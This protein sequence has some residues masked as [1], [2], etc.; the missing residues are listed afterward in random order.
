MKKALVNS[1]PVPVPEEGG[2]WTEVQTIQDI[3]IL[4][5]FNNHVLKA[6]HCV[7]TDTGEHATLKAGV[8]HKSQIYDAYGMIYEY[9][10]SRE[11]IKEVRISGKGRELIRKSINCTDAWVKKKGNEYGLIQWMEQNYNKEK[12]EGA[13]QRRI[14]RVNAIMSKVPEAPEDLKEWI[15]RAANGGMDYCIRN[16]ETKQ[17]TCSRCGA[18]FEEKR[19]V[20]VDGSKKVRNNDM[21]LCPEC[22]TAVQLKRRVHSRDIRVHF[23]LVQPIDEECS[24]MRHFD[25][26]IICKGKKQ[27]DLDE[28][29]RLIL[30][31]KRRDIGCTIYYNQ[32][33]ES[34][35]RR[36]SL[37]GVFDNKGNPRNRRM[38]EGYLYDGGVGEAFRGTK[39]EP[40][41]R[42]FIRAAADGAKLDYNKLMCMEDTDAPG[43]FE[44][45]YKGRFYNLS[46]EESG[47]IDAWNGTYMGKLN[48][49][50]ETIEDVFG[51]RDRQKI[52]RI[53]DR[54]GGGNMVE[55][56][57]WS[58]R[59]RKKISEKALCWLLTNKI[60]PEDMT[61]MELRFSLEQ[62]ANYI[63]RQ[64][65]ESYPR[66]G[67][68][69]VIDQ[70]EDY[71]AMCEKL[72][73]DTTD[74]MVYRPRELKRRHGEVVAELR[75][76]EAE[77]KAEEY[78][79]KFGEA[80]RV[81]QQIKE[82]LEYRGGRYLIV[83]PDRIVDIVNEGRALHHCVGNTERYFDR[84][85][86]QE[87]YICFLRKTEEPE[88]AYYTIEVEPGGTIRQHRGMYD[89]EPEIDE[90]RPF[91]RE[92]QRVIRRRMTKKD[93]ELET[94][95]AKMREANIRELKEKNNTRVLQGLM[96]DFMAIT[97]ETA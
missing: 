35:A 26:W 60:R 47:K 49:R 76:R 75:M 87:T 36:W 6:R 25:G 59:H 32:Y 97:E 16:H 20:R 84:I 44:M 12:R 14:E 42:M 67:A 83:V 95:S 96:E 73:K 64:K 23:S 40:W 80:E 11:P 9:Y 89:E 4:N 72:H 28:S 69:G 56:M 29:V 85:K 8:W 82:K 66:L 51:I 54:D 46:R 50:G 13:E 34:Y 57:R 2:W 74:E 24:V 38:Q 90:I 58:E 88:K 65:K 41:I 33:T 48:L 71:M 17:M 77:L 21:V 5:V 22:G 79:K 10:G 45:L 19:L 62:A 68:K 37:G 7:N 15:D 43:V 86:Q 81:L 70:Y 18:E 61:W 30:H 94:V 27:V 3:L 53:R 1:V 63:E 52:N 31:K 78:S 91:L 55:W 93:R 39:Y 92:W